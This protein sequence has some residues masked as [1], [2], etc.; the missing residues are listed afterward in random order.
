MHPDGGEKT[1]AGGNPSQ[2]ANRIRGVVRPASAEARA[3]CKDPVP[4]ICAPMGL[5][6]TVGPKGPVYSDYAILQVFMGYE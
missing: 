3:R 4:A 2:A 5:A 1:K 6:L